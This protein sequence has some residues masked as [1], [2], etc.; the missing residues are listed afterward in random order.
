[1]H[2]SIVITKKFN[3][4]SSIFFVKICNLIGISSEL[5]FLDKHKPHY[6]F[7]NPASRQFFLNVLNYFT[8]SSISVHS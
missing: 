8:Q 7:K 3:L 2:D 6:E 5:I 1:M 4:P